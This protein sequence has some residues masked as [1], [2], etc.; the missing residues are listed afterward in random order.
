MTIMASPEEIPWAFVA[1]IAD[2]SERHEAEREREQLLRRL[3]VAVRE[4]E[5]RFDAIVGG[6]ERRGHDP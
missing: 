3:E 5:L 2:V 6:A 4:S 1:F